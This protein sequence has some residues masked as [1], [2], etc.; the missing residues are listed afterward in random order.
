MAVVVS[1]EHV[2]KQYDG[3]APILSDV[4]LE[5][6]RGAETNTWFMSEAILCIELE[7]KTGLKPV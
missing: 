3:D 1:L 4:S 2:G 6:E 7:K 5:L